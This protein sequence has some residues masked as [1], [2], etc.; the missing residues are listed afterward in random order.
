MAIKG[1]AQV[2]KARRHRG[3]GGA[4]GGTCD[5]GAS[6]TSMTVTTTTE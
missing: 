5:T 6:M 3:N 1:M 4:N 2:F